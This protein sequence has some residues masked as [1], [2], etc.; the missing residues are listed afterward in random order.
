MDRIKHM[1]KMRMRRKRALCR[2][3][4]GIINYIY[5]YSVICLKDNS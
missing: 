3:Q 2:I 5:I 4:E 1:A